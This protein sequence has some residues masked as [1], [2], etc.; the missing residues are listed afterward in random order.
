MN[1]Y[2]YLVRASKKTF[3]FDKEMFLKFVNRNSDGLWS[4]SVGHLNSYSGFTDSQELTIKQFEEIFNPKE[5]K[6]LLK[7][8]RYKFGNTFINDAK[9]FNM[10]VYERYGEIEKNEIC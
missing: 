9:F 5:I 7:Y 2:L 3:L 8:K 1:D 10:R 6:P 4:F